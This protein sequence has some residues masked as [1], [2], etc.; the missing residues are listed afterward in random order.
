[1]ALAGRW[2][3]VG[4][5]RRGP[6]GSKGHSGTSLGVLGSLL[7]PEVLMGPVWLAGRWGSDYNPRNDIAKGFLLDDIT[8]RNRVAV[9]LHKINDN[10]AIDRC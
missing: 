7:R 8:P 6:K 1:M 10:H 4:N 2:A 9:W 5:G 3:L